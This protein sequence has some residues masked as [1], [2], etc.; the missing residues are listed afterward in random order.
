VTH[1]A[2][3]ILAAVLVAGSIEAQKQQGEPRRPTL[4][5]NADTNESQSYYDFGQQ[6]LRESP[7][8]AADAF[9][10]AARINP[11]RADAFYARRVALLLSNPDRLARYWR[12]ERSVIRSADI[13]RIDSLYLHALTLNPFFYEGLERRLQDE[14]IAVAAKRDAAVYGVSAGEVEYVIQRYLQTAGPGEKAF[15]AYSD[16]RFE[17]ALSLYASAIKSERIKYPYRMMRGR[18]FFQLNNVDSAL[19]ELT[20]AVADMRKR[21]AKDLIYVYQSKALLEQAIGMAH[22][23]RGERDKAKE[24]FGRALQEDLAYSSAHTQL[25]YLALETADTTTAIAEFDLAVQLRTDDAGLRY[26]YGFML[27]ET[28]RVTEG[29]EQLRTAVKLNPVYALPRYG[30][31]RALEK[32]QKTA[33]AIVEY[34]AFLTLASRQDPRRSEAEQ[35]I[36]ALQSQ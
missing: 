27:V 10:W 11:T 33:E 34:Q 36:K 30:L 21:D 13:Q 32:Q 35:R 6:Q 28:G 15:R 23:R 31:G 20:L 29:E 26:Q 17:E 1:R 4:W 8:T 22:H 12:G 3:V 7:A 2:L 24:A 25:A 9:Y 16:G 5:A 14:V 18:L 19:N